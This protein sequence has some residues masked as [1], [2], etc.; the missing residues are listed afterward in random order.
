[1]VSKNLK[2]TLERIVLA[3]SIMMTPMAAKAEPIQY[4]NRHN[5]SARAAVLGANVAFGCLKAGIGSS[6]NDKGFL[7]GCLKG[8]LGGA[9][10]YAGEELA[11]H[12]RYPMVGAAGKLTHDLGISVQDNVMMGEGMFSRYQTDIGPVMLTFKDS[13]VPRGSFT[14]TPA[15]GIAKSLLNENKLDA[16]QSLYNLTPVFRFSSDNLR[17]GSE[18]IPV[19]GVTY[20]NVISYSGSGEVLSHEMNHAIGW[21]ELRF[22]KNIAD[23][24]PTEKI[25]PSLEM[26]KI[27]RW[28]DIGQDVCGV[29]AYL[30]T[31]MLNEGYYYDP[32]ELRAYTM[33]RE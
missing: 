29:V 18:V 7:N 21:S 30:P 26:E 9:V 16:R 1:M 12:N 31:V 3:A 10:A 8:M 23:K 2:K 4:I 6:A 17:I 11:S 15:V 13:I 33:Q 19:L 22:C 27:Q 25:H 14:L 5:T 28:W 20:G 32:A 24:V